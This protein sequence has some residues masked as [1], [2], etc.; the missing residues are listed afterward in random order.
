MYRRKTGPRGSYIKDADWQ[1][2][3][4]PTGS[5][6]TAIVDAGNVIY[7]HSE[8]PSHGWSNPSMVVR[9]EIMSIEWVSGSSG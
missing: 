2:W 9:N 1:T 5:T 8:Q 7:F 3:G 4:T 6:I